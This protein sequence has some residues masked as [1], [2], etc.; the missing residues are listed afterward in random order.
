MWKYT[1]IYI[2]L[3]KLLVIIVKFF[4]LFSDIPLLPAMNASQGV[5]YDNF[6]VH[7]LN[8]KELH[9]TKQAEKL[10]SEMNKKCDIGGETSATDTDETEHTTADTTT[11]EDE[12]TAEKPVHSKHRS[13]FM[14][15]SQ[16]P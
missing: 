10:L 3:K 4:S 13:M 16:I 15:V 12:I 14:L 6:V 9:F 2:L 8:N 1:C 7:W 11:E 5:Q